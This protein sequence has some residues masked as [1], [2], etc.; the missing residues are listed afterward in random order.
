VTLHEFE[1]FTP[2]DLRYL[3]LALRAFPGV[4]HG[5]RAR[6]LRFPV[7]GAQALREAVD[8]SGARHGGSEIPVE[9]LPELMPEFYFPIE[10]EEDF[11]AKVADACGRQ[12][13]PDGPNLPTVVLMEAKAARRG[14]PPTITD[15]EIFRLAGIR[16]SD[17]A[18][19]S[20]GGLAKHGRRRG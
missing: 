6:R 3:N 15:D 20:V 8:A 18:T 7:E 14:D 2:D 5:L 17:P 10:S 13:E 12:R 16:T 1:E 11:V 19:P 9:H 4:A